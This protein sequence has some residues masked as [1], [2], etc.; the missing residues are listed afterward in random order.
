MSSWWWFLVW[1]PGTVLDSLRHYR[2]KQLLWCP[3]KTWRTSSPSSK[4]ATAIPSPSCFITMLAP[5]PFFRWA[6]SGLKILRM[7]SCLPVNR[8]FKVKFFSFFLNKSGIAHTLLGFV[9][10]VL[11]RSYHRN[12]RFCC[13]Y[14]KFWNSWTFSSLEA[15]L[16]PL[17]F[18]LC[19][20]IFRF[21][22]S[23]PDRPVRVCRPSDM[24]LIFLH[25]FQ[26]LVFFL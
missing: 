23:F 8:F 24:I 18:F 10:L 1:R 13:I 25:P 3:T 6:M 9:K 21:S 26:S 11:N 5:P 16:V 19:H 7:L 12:F 2:Q 4:E 22:F 14:V 15:L 17:R 20:S